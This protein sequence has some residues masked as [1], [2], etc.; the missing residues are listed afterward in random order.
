MRLHVTGFSQ[1]ALG[2]STSQTCT[3]L[4]PWST[5]VLNPIQVVYLGA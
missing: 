2:C 4:K 3:H 5:Q 1:T